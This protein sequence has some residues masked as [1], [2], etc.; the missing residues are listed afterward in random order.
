[1]AETDVL[2]DVRGSAFEIRGRRVYDSGNP[3]PGTLTF[4]VSNGS[5]EWIDLVVESFY[6]QSSVIWTTGRI[7]DR[8]A[9]SHSEELKFHVGKGVHIKRWRPGLFGIPGD[10]GGEVFFELPDNGDVTVDVT[11]TG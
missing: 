4:N 11:V 10:G 2:F 1:M 7:G 3:Q 6:P 8:E 9:V 5:G